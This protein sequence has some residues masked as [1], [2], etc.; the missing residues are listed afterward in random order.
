MESRRPLGHVKAFC[1]GVLRPARRVVDEEVRNTRESNARLGRDLVAFVALASLA[2]VVLSVLARLMYFSKYPNMDVEDF[3][4]FHPV[5][6]WMTLGGSVLYVVAVYLKGVRYWLVY[7]PAVLAIVS[8][9]LFLALL[10]GVVVPSDLEVFDFGPD[11][12]R[13]E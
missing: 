7:V 11:W 2:S 5:V 10:H 6:P 4:A 9:A 3:E 8:S 12:W 13:G 1:V